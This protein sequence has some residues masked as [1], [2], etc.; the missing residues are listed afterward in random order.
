M[1]CGECCCEEFE[2]VGEYVERLVKFWRH[3]IAALLEG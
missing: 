1:F 3:I 2:R